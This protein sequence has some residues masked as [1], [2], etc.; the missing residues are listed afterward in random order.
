MREATLCFLVRGQPPAE[1]L[2]GFKKVRFGQGKYNGFGGKVDVG[3]TVAEAAVRE[4]KEEI[5]V[6]VNPLHLQRVGQLAFHFPTRPAWDQRVHVFIT[7]KWQGT[8][9]GRE[10]MRPAWVAVDAIP[11][12]QMWADDVH[13]LPS[14]LKGECIQG[15]FEFG[16][17]GETI[18][19]FAVEI[20]E[21]QSL[22]LPSSTVSLA[23]LKKERSHREDAKTARVFKVKA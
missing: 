17:D 18:H 4:V 15:W 13:W 14:V 7:R 23:T 22:N 10:E 16:A 6:D 1:I 2:L 11:Y 12:Q 9:A 3:E 20:W 5:G 8:P 21:A 19:S